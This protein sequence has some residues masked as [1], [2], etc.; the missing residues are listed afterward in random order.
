MRPSKPRTRLGTSLYASGGS[1]GRRVSARTCTTLCCT[2]P[3]DSC[4]QDTHAHQEPSTS[5]FS[6]HSRCPVT[7]TDSSTSGGAHGG[8]T[9]VISQVCETLFDSA[10]CRPGPGPGPFLGYDH[11]AVVL[12]RGRVGGRPGAG[13]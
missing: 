3:P 11:A 10:G 6:Q 13:G 12:G 8:G 4:T 1:S 2:R 5:T 7:P 9:R